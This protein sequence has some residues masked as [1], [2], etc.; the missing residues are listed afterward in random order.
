[1]KTLKETILDVVSGKTLEENYGEKNWHE[2]DEVLDLQHTFDPHPIDVHPEY[3]SE[4]EIPSIK[5]PHHVT[6]EYTD[7]RN[8][9]TIG[10]V[11]ITPDDFRDS[12]TF[13]MH[14]AHYLPKN[15]TG[16]FKT[17]DI[18][19][20]WLMD[21]HEHEKKWKPSIIKKNHDIY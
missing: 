16:Y 2:I 5:F 7:K 6:M 4:K 8:N 1:M 17:P 10:Y 3:E 15:R 19:K 20:S 21:T 13:G 11:M 18:A 12:D 14:Y 9:K